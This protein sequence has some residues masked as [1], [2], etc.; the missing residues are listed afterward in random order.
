MSKEQFL[1][2]ASMMRSV[3]RGQME[4]EAR[5]ASLRDEVSNLKGELAR[6]HQVGSEVDGELKEMNRI[7]RK[8]KN[9]L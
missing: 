4:V 3:L 9:K 8:I 2:L 5:I 7:G 1:T 6:L